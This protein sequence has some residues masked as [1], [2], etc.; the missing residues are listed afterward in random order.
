MD[1]WWALASVATLLLSGTVAQACAGESKGGNGTGGS[2]GTAGTAA[3]GGGTASG[4]SSETGGSEN[5]GSGGSQPVDATSCQTATDCGWG[6]ID[7]EILESTDCICL[8]GCPYLPLSQDAIDR[9]LEQYQNLCNP[10][11]DGAGNPCP[12]DECMMPPDPTCVDNVCG[13]VDPFG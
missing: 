6:E 3:L 2:A 12:I 8:L 9:R 11:V 4:G 10:Q 5:Q 1:R 7:H 13:P